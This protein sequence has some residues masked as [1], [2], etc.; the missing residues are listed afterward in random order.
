MVFVPDFDLLAAEWEG[1]ATI[2]QRVGAEKAVFDLQVA[3]KDLE[4]NTRGAA[5]H[6][7]VLEPLL[8]RLVDPETFKVGMC[9][10]PDL[11]EQLLAI[12]VFIQ[13]LCF[14]SGFAFHHPCCFCF[15]IGAVDL[16]FHSAT[17]NQ[18]FTWSCPCFIAQQGH[19][20]DLYLGNKNN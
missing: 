5:H 13:C 3:G 10:I 15:I 17:P 19:E 7:S 2:R 14:C 6:A 4:V 18:N 8:K 11:E 20:L 9:R 1:D 16:E 12:D